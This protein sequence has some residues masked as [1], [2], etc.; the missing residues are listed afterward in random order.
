[1]DLPKASQLALSGLINEPQSGAGGQSRGVPRGR[2]FFS[3][4]F[5]GSRIVPLDVEKPQVQRELEQLQAETPQ[6]AAPNGWDRSLLQAF[7]LG[8]RSAL[9]RVYRAFAQDIAGLLRKGFAFESRGRR[10]HF[11]GYRSP[12][13]LHDALHETFRRAFEPGARQAYDGIRPYA[14]YLRTIARNFVLGEFR[15]REAL[16]VDVEQGGKLDETTPLH[17]EPAPSPEGAVASQQ[18][19]ELVQDFLQGLPTQERQ[20]LNLR[21]VE[22]LS[23]RD[24]AEQL[25]LGRQRLRGRENKLRRKLV[26]FLRERGET[27]LMPSSA[28]AWIAFLGSDLGEALVGNLPLRQRTTGAPA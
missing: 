21:F 7:R 1:V 27:D 15:R 11:V 25:G 22:G 28:L 24:A 12:H 5:G 4:H 3:T 17:V 6:L 18:V 8:E 23:Q 10:R 26:R 16:F 2:A 13:D 20:L 14:P 9:E 19:R